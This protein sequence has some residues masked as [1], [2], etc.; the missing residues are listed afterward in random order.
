MSHWNHNSVQLHAIIVACLWVA[1]I[2]WTGSRLTF[3]QTFELFNENGWMVENA[4]NSSEVTK[5]RLSINCQS[6]E[7][8]WLIECLCK[9][10]CVSIQSQKSI[11]LGEE[12]R[13]SFHAAF[14]RSRSITL[15]ITRAIHWCGT[16]T[17][18]VKMATAQ[19]EKRVSTSP[20]L[21]PKKLPSGCCNP[22]T[23]LATASR[24]ISSN[25]S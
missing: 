23:Y 6:S 22:L 25:R 18:K 13:Y 24:S 12:K 10:E 16:L 1:W 20:H 15:L 5:S 3:I 4:W 11:K 21:S 9:I 7:D 8:W 14:S 19:N 2:D 17:I